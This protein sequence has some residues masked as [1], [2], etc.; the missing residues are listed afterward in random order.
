MTFQ[1]SLRSVL[2]LVLLSTVSFVAIAQDAIERIWYNQEKTA[3]VQIFKATDGK[4][5]GKIVWLKEPNNEEGKP[6]VDKNNP[7][8]AKKST[9]LMGLQL[10]KGFKKDGDTEYEDGTIYDPKNG[11]TYSCKINRK[12][13]TL[14]VRGYVGISLIGR[15]TIWTKAD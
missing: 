7:D 13:E 3:K 12:G 10:L 8:K 5:Y 4:F 2:L 15:T 9:P 11:K 1:A 6:K 14:E